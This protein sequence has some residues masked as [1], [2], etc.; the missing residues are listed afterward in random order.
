[1]PEM[2]SLSYAQTGGCWHE[3]AGGGLNRRCVFHVIGLGSIFG[4]P[5]GLELR[6][7]GRIKKQG[8]QQSF[9]IF[10]PFWANYC[11]D[12]RSEFYFHKQ[13]DH[14]PLTNQSLGLP[15]LSFSY[16]KMSNSGKGRYQVL[17]FLRISC[18]HSQ[19]YLKIFLTFL[20][21]H[22]HD[23]HLSRLCRSIYN[24]TQQTSIMTHMTRTGIMNSPCKMTE[25]QEPPVA[26]PRLRT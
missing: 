24:K 21:L 14:Y 20:L 5:V 18:L 17:Y 2:G 8:S 26:Y 3:E 11:R 12:C 6:G 10:W 7:R 16:R 1:M 15:I 22:H 13:S 9:T 4:F 19:Q 25:S 23:N